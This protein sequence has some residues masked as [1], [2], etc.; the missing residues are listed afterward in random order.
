ERSGHAGICARPDRVRRSDRAVLCVLVVIEEHAVAFFFPPLARGYRGGT[1]LDF[2]RE[3]QSG[4]ANFRERPALLDAHVPV[5]PAPSRRLRPAD[6]AKV[7]ERCAHDLSD[8]TNLAPFDAGHRI[9][10]DAQL[11]GVIEIVG[12]DRMRMELEASQ[13]RHPA[14]CRG[15]PR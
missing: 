3:R 1:T 10:I 12:P 11:V 9:E 7:L 14:E 4:P 15:V 5:L 8:I 2:A 13:I 6:D